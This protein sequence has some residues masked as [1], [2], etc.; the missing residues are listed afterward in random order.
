[1]GVN[2]TGA[3]YKGLTFNGFN[4]KDFGV[5]ITGEAVYNAPER[6]VEMIDIPGRNGSFARDNGR[7]NNIIVEYTAGMFGDAQTDFAE[8]ISEF[9]NALCASVGYC[10]L[11]DEYN[12][13][14][15]R[16]AVYKSGLDVSPELMGRAG[17]FKITFECKPQRFLKSGEI[18]QTI[19][20]SGDTLE[21]PTRFASRPL[22]EVTGYG[23]IGLN[24]DEVEIISGPIGRT[25]LLLNK[26]MTKGAALT[27]TFNFSPNYANMNSGDSAQILGGNITVDFGVTLMD[28]YNFSQTG[29]FVRSA[30]GLNTNVLTFDLYNFVYQY[31][32]AKTASASVEVGVYVGG[33]V[34]QYATI[35]VSLSISAAGAISITVSTGNLG[36]DSFGLSLPAI[37]GVSSKSALGD[38][39]YIDLDIGEAYKIEGGAVVGVNSAVSLGGE[40]P[41]LQPGENTITFSRNVTALKIK[42]RWWK[43]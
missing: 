30:T 29:N 26:R 42:P 33:T 39:V 11:E 41:E 7:F 8:G 25:P 20:A 37:F 9:R 31:G 32:T 36:A 3:I 34:A 6:D 23:T 22:L 2:V 16:E 38:P 43:V 28:I 15:Y 1:M 13:D 12:P 19:A 21:N 5:Y 17:E 10:R 27:A 35:T 14:E 40:L 18:A 24:G 4:S